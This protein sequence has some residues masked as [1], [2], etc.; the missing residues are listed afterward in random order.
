MILYFYCLFFFHP[1]ETI[2]SGGACVLAP[3]IFEQSLLMFLDDL[4]SFLEV[5][6][7][8]CFGEMLQFGL[9]VLFSR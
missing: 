7:F 6:W 8:V 5:L 9:Y 2:F 1:F 3:Y 4:T